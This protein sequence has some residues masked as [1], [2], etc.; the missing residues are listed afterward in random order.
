MR[1]ADKVIRRFKIKKEPIGPNGPVRWVVYTRHVD[2]LDWA[3]LNYHYDYEG[4]R[5]QTARLVDM[6]SRFVRTFKTA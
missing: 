2:D 6:V 3:Y 1:K 5:R 4:A